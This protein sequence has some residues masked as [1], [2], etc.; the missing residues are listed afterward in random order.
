MDNLR[1]VL[2]VT[3]LLMVAEDWAVG[4]TFLQTQCLKKLI[5]NDENRWGA[6]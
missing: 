2:Y 5:D 3:Q 1:R 4:P 6:E